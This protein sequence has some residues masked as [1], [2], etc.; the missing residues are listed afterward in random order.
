[1]DVGLHST[2]IIFGEPTGVP[3]RE[4]DL[5]PTGVPAWEPISVP[6]RKLDL[7]PTGVSTWEPTIDAPERRNK[8]RER[9]GILLTIIPAR[10]GLV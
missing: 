10:R 3:T 5:C 2:L 4:L 9:T 7:R 6:T 8:N 1:M